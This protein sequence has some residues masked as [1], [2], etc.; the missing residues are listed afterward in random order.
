MR[1]ELYSIRLAPT[2]RR[3]L[4][5]VRALVGDETGRLEAV[6]FNQRHLLRA[7]APGDQLMIRGT[8]GTGRTAIDHRARL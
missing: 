5:T 2:R 6:W 8:I 1:V 3:G 4:V 7:L